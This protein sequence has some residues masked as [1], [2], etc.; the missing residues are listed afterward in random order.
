MKKLLFAALLGANL[1]AA[2]TPSV[3]TSAQPKETNTVST[4]SNVVVIIET[5]EGNITAELFADKAPIT[6]SNFLA[7]VDSKFYDGTIF[8]RVIKGFMIQGGGFTAKMAQKPTRP[9]IQNEAANG[10]KNDRGTLSMARRGD[11]NSA[12]SQFF[13]NHKNNASLNRPSP[14]GHG[15]AV[16]GKVIEGMDVVDK[17]AAVP[18]GMGDVPVKTV[19]I[20]SIRLKADAPAKP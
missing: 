9:T 18:T 5:S 13:I 8:H 3:A 15:Y 4:V 1:A 10:L 12:S 11:P 2:Q 7:Y 16:F 6:V 19:E 14:D 17:I 20:K